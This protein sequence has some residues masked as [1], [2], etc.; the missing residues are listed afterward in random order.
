MFARIE[1]VTT[2]D[3]Y[4]LIHHKKFSGILALQ[5]SDQHNLQES[6][7]VKIYTT[8]HHRALVTLEHI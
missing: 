1:E 7:K 6:Y 8:G 2:R 5:T 4:L 3:P